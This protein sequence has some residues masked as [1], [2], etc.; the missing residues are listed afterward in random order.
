MRTTIDLP[1]ELRQKLISEAASKN[2]KGYSNII[3]EALNKYFKTESNER[4][5]KI[6]ELKG[7][8]NEDEFKNDMKRVKEGRSNWKKW[9]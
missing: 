1:T 3:I 5:K 4:I 9:F 8:L 7:C 2:L 6:H